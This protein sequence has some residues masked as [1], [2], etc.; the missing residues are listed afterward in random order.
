MSSSYAITSLKN[1]MVTWR[2][3]WDGWWGFPYLSLA[4]FQDMMELSQRQT[5]EGKTS[6]FK[7]L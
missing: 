3:N 6:R 7:I 5:D 1:L 4:R 2:L